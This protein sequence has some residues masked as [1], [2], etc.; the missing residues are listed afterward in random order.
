MNA[1]N[2]VSAAANSIFGLDSIYEESI[3]LYRNLHNVRLDLELSYKD[4]TLGF[5]ANYQSKMVN[6]D[7][8]LIGEGYFGQLIEFFN[9][10]NDV[11]PGMKD[12]KENQASGDWVFDLRF[13][14]AVTDDL[15]LSFVI[16]NVMNREYALRIGRINPPRQFT[17]KL[18]VGI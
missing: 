6:V 13:N 8:V 11:F 2:F 18:Q 4:L 7:D 14:Y 9:G 5:A 15:K 12:Y 17:L 3:L 10:G 1:G 16:N